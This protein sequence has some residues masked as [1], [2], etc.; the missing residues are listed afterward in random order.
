MYQPTVLAWH[1]HKKK[2]GEV[3]E[4]VSGEFPKE[5]DNFQINLWKIIEKK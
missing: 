5:G 2:S 1:K 3:S 4:F